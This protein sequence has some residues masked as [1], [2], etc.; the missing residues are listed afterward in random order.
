MYFY[1]INGGDVSGADN[2]DSST[3]V[4]TGVLNT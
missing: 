1:I 2:V 4:L 3:D